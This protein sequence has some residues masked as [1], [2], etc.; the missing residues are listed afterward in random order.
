MAPALPTYGG[1]LTSASGY[2]EALARQKASGSPVLVYF[3]TDWC[4]YCRQFDASVAPLADPKLLRVR[5]NPDA[6]GFDKQL[7]AQFG[8]TGYPSLFLISRAGAA[9]R[10]VND[11]V[12]RNAPPN[13]QAFVDSCK[14]IVVNELLRAGLSA[15]SG[16]TPDLDRALQFDPGRA[17]ILNA[18]SAI[19]W[20]AGYRKSAL[21][22]ASR[23]CALGDATDC[24]NARG[25]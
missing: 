3:Y 24:R 23:A 15:T 6:G 14:E 9:H 20:K 4:P 2:D 17:A 16:E 1:W 13:P 10:P 19:R 18:R 22:D 12:Q 21:E 7:A 11:G 25:S 5:V 8:V